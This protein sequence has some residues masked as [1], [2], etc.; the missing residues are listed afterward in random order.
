MGSELLYTAHL[1]SYLMIYGVPTFYYVN[2]T[3][4]NFLE[5]CIYFI[6]RQ[7]PSK[8]YQFKF[9]AS[10]CIWGRGIFTSMRT[11]LLIAKSLPLRSLLKYSWTRLNLLHI[12]ISCWL[13][14]RIAFSLLFF[15][16]CNVYIPMINSLELFLKIINGKP[17]L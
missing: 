8:N 11:E 10:G 2:K 4:V 12:L 5:L 15:P 14:F 9:L 3:T 16:H 13:F 17:I 7:I 6:I 1:T